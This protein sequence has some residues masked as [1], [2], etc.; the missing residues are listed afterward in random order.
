M[1]IVPIAM[2]QELES[3]PAPQ[4]AA[5]IVLASSDLAA[6]NALRDGAAVFLHGARHITRFTGAKSAETL[7]GLVTN[8]VTQ[9]AVGRGLYA[10]ALQP[11]GK[12]LADLAILRVEPET[13]LVETSELAGREWFAMIRKYVNPRLS[14][15][16]DE[17]ASYTQLA[18]YGKHAPAVLAKLG[19]GAMG[20]AEL[21]TAM[22]QGL[23]SWPDWAHANFALSG[24][25]VRLI[26]APHVGELRGFIVLVDSAS[27]GEARRQIERAGAVPGSE[28]V[29]AMAQL[30]SGRPVFGRDMDATTIPQEAN[31]DDWSAISYEKG[32]YTGQETVARVHFRGHVNKHLRGLSAN[33]ELVPGATVHDAAGKAVG[34]VRR[35]GRSPRLGHI[36]IGMIRREVPTGTTVTVRLADTETSATVKSTTFDN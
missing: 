1:I 16:K 25:T 36:A 15:Y 5:P 18:V 7:N 13:F 27:A 8:D 21:T 34:D 20:D 14:Q 3:E 9:I 33:S 2:S 23:E 19:V 11:K 29:W 4:Y 31:L 32:C 35:S 26:R 24:L 12:M 28:A 22:Q 10:A 6:Y 17:S 30:E